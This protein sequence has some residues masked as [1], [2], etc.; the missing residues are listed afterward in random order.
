MENRRGFIFS[1]A[2]AL[3]LAPAL[4][5]TDPVPAPDGKPQAAVIPGK[6]PIM[7][8]GDGLKIPLSKDAFLTLWEDKSFWLT[9]GVGRS[10]YSQRAEGEGVKFA[11]GAMELLILTL[12]FAPDRLEHVND[13]GWRLKDPKAKNYVLGNIDLPGEPFWPITDA[14]MSGFG[15]T[16]S[17][18]LNAPP[19]GTMAGGPN[20]Q[21]GSS[22]NSSLGDNRVDAFTAYMVKKKDVDLA[23]VRARAQLL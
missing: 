12:A 22:W 20:W 2:G 15:G 16:D 10:S 23:Y 13:C 1:L 8:F 5:A 11:K 18:G 19:S 4:A 21:P 7:D 17:P 6:P 9:Y 14:G 3:T